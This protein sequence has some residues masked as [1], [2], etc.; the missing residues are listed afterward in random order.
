M[1]KL[2][3]ANTHFA[4]CFQGMKNGDKRLNMKEIKKK[5]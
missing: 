5:V 3:G 4:M 2:N 1:H